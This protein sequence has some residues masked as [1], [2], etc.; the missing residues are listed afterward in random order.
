[1]QNFSEIKE[2]HPHTKIIIGGDFNCPGID[3]E[4]GFLSAESY[5]SRLLREKL[6]TFLQDF[7]LNQ[8]VNFPTRGINILD[9]C[10]TSHPNIISTCNSIPGFSDHDAILVSLSVSFYQQKQEPHRV[11]LYK[12]ANWDIIQSRLSDLSHEYFNLNSTSVRTVDENWSPFQENFQ[13]IIDDHVPFKTLRKNT[14]LPW[15]TAELA[16]LIRKK[17]RVYKR[18]KLHKRD[19]NWSEY[20]NLQRKVRQMLK[21]KH[22][23][24][25]TNII[26]SSNDNKLFWRY[27]KAKQQDTTGITTLKG[28]G[29]EAITE[30]IDKANI[31]NEH[32]KSTFTTEQFDNFP[33]KSNSPYPSMPHFEIT[34]QGV[35][36]ILNEGN[37]NKSPGPDKLHPYALRATAAEI[38]P[39]LTHIFQQSLSYSRLPTQWK[40]A[41][42]TPVYKKGDKSDPKN[43]HPISLTSVICK[44]M[45]H[46]IVSQLMKHLESTNILAE[47]QFGFREHHSCESQLLVTVNDIAKA[48]NNKLQVDLAVLDFSKAFDKVAHARLLEYYVVRG[49]LLEWFESFLHNRTQQVVIEGRY[50]ISCDITSGVP[51]GSV[52]GPAL[53]LI[54]INDISTN[55][56]SELRLFADDIL[57]YRPIHSP[58]DQKILQDDLT[59]LIKWAN[60]WQMDFNVSKCNILQVTTHHTTKTFTYQM[61][62]VPLKSVEKIKYL[63]VYLNNKLS[64]HDHIDYICNKANRLLGFLKQN[65]HSCHKHF[66]EYVYKQFLLPSIEYCCAIWDPHHQNDISKLEMIQHRAARFVLNKSWNRHHRDSITDMLNELNWPPLQERRKQARLILLYKIV[67]HL[68]LVPNRCLPSLN[69]TATRAHHDQKFNHM[70]SSVNTYLYSFLPRTIP[71]WNDLCIPNLSTIDLETFKQSTTPTL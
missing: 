64:W 57:I 19:S 68:L 70:Q 1:M 69:Q 54:Y 15:M 33:S 39:M 49:S 62:G 4:H 21:H 6:L 2:K 3:W 67:N 66:K 35:Y 43:Y 20:K 28:P 55:M 34:T 53:F 16:R 37:S 51:Q 9:L 38:S 23:A 30:S 31:L 18:A 45:E 71:H 50:S 60:E 56:H 12:K 32:F 25:I 63:G 36:N 46:I 61:N 7:H 42:V 26:S 27:I 44:T 8:I 17:K 59:T 14:C 47:N 24:Y 58:S 40:H 13:S 29:G 5:T 41:Y 22:R 10:F 48:I 52:L 11:P 65:L